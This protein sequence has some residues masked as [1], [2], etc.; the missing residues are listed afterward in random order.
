[1]SINWYSNNL[2]YKKGVRYTFFAVVNWQNSSNR[3][4]KNIE[5]K[6]KTRPIIMDLLE[7]KSK[8]MP[9]K[10]HLSSCHTVF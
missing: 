10:Y 7:V 5:K 1:M 2:L 3:N 4:L 6:K 9:E 8:S